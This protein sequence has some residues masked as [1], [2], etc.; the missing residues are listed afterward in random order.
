MGIKESGTILI[1]NLFKRV[2]PQGLCMRHSCGLESTQM[3]MF[4]FILLT[5]P[6]SNNN[7]TKPGRAIATACANYC[8][9]YNGRQI[10]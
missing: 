7:N 10:L 4:Y 6:G 1:S 8:D 9:P 2:A 5:L 3:S